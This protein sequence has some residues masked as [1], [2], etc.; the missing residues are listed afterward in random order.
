MTKERGQEFLPEDVELL[1][2]L[3]SHLAVALECA[4]A[5]D[6]AERYQ[7][8]VAKERDRLKLLLEINNHIVSKL[9]I[10]DLF[11]SASAS[12]RTYFHNDFTGFW[13]H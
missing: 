13:L 2:S 12:I 11:R 7:L 1:G 10:N 3:A 9:D 6:S 5:R 4:V 8:Q